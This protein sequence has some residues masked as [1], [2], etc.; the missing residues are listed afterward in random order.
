MVRDLTG[1][2]MKLGVTNKIVGLGDRHSSS[3]TF[4][5]KVVLSTNEEALIPRLGVPSTAGFSRILLRAVWEADVVHIHEIWHFPQ[6]LSA[7]AARARG[8]PFVLTPHGELKPW[9]FRQLRILKAIAWHT[10]QRRILAA[11]QGLHVLTAEEKGS[12]SQMGITTRMR[13]IPNGVDIERIEQS[14]RA[15]TDSEKRGLDL[16]RPYILYVGRIAV[17]KGLNT[18]IDAF[19]AVSKLLPEYSLVI[20]GPDRSGLWESLKARAERLGIGGRVIY[21][22]FIDEPMKFLFLANAALYVLPSIS[23]G[24][25]ISLLEALACGTPVIASE[26]CNVPEIE[27]SGAGRVVTP[28]ETGLSR[29]L[30]EL[31]GDQRLI[32]S[33]GRNAKVLAKNQFSIDRMARDILDFYREL[34]R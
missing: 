25:S 31:L 1:A 33:M 9:P 2:L 5:E 12:V 3:V 34:L 23:E 28:T 32:R 10:Y 30:L 29:E 21:L 22:G 7:L 14:L 15:V 19:A 20:I 6:V 13:V 26:G 11:A 24:L 4:P 18:L 17:G 8:T 16:Q 27:T